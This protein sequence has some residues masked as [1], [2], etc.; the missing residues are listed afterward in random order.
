MPGKRG[1]YDMPVNDDWT[2]PD[3]EEKT[4]FRSDELQELTSRVSQLEGKLKAALD[5]IQHTAFGRT[6]CLRFEDIVYLNR[7]WGA[8]I[9]GD[10]HGH[11]I[12][13]FRYLEGYKDIVDLV[14]LRTGASKQRGCPVPLLVKIF[15]CFSIAMIIIF[16]L[17]LL[18][19]LGVL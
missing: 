12:M 4:I 10:V 14:A 6:Q 1:P 5:S 13:L 19:R 2:P 9:I 11:Q 3:E 16:A 7:G 8:A 15:G 17:G 18:F